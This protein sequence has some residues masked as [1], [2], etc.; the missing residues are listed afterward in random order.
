MLPK[1]T[2]LYVRRIGKRHGTPKQFAKKCKDHGL[3]WIA[4]GGVWQERRHSGNVTSL[5]MNRPDVIARYGQALEAAGV[6]VSIWGYPWIDHE[7]KFVEQMMRAAVELPH[8]RIL[9]DPELGSNPARKSKGPEKARANKHARKLVTLFDEHPDAPEWLGL[10]TFGNGWRIGWFP[11]H[12]FTKALVE[13]YGGNTFIGGQTYTDNAV[14]DRSIGDMR[15]AIEKSGGIVQLPSEKPKSAGCAIVPNF[16]TYTWT[17]DGKRG[18]RRKGAKAVSKT[19]D[20]LRMHLYEFVNE[21]EPI[22]AMIGWAENFVRKAQWNV[23][24][25]FADMLERGACVL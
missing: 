5:Y 18:R 12:A 9:L 20:E 2:S 21:G 25:E 24:A 6:E 3:S 10:S 14:I 7:E 23:L 15:K 17:K 16:G 19:Q 11:M 13:C 22:E 4:L 8:Q 1:G